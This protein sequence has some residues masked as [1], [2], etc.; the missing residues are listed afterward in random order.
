M[1]TA[2]PTSQIGRK[3]SAAVWTAVAPP[4]AR[5]TTR[6]AASTTKPIPRT[7]GVCTRPDSLHL[8]DVQPADLPVGTEVEAEVGGEVAPLLGVELPDD[9]ESIGAGAIDRGEAL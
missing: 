1:F 7:M 6:P 9:L 3:A 4:T 5:P 2:A 8:A